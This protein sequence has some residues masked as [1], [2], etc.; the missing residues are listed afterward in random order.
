MVCPRHAKHELQ[1]HNKPFNARLTHAWGTQLK[2]YHKIGTCMYVAYNDV[3]NC[4]KHIPG[5]FL[6]ACNARRSV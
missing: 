4:A 2:Q 6:R 3:P 1:A 5:V